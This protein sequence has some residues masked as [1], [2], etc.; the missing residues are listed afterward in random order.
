MTTH[1]S[2]ERAF[3][4]L[5]AR[6]PRWDLVASMTTRQVASIINRAGLGTQRAR[7]IKRLLASVHA[8]LGVYSLDELDGWTDPEVEAFLTDLP[9]VGLKTAKCVM[10]YALRRPVL[11]VD[12]HVWRIA[13]R[14]GLIDPRTPYSRV[15]AEL[16]RVV[17]GRDRYAFH[18]NCISHG[19]AVCRATGAPRCSECVIRGLCPRV[20]VASPLRHR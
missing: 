19:R 20:G 7:N 1:Q 6:A 3:R 18:V 10:M 12:T 15:H 4:A 8:R 9:G 13:R 16:E 5:K 11:P 14:L 17:D 2:Y